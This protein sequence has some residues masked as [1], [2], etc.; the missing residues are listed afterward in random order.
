MASAIPQWYKYE[1]VDGTAAGALYG[2]YVNIRPEPSL[3]DF[4]DPL[5]G[6]SMYPSLLYP[7]RAWYLVATFLVRLLPA[8][9]VVLLSN[10]QMTA[11]PTLL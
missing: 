4:Q 8:M 9:A 2:P 5:E 6:L 3:E 10:A 1:S 7:R 11:A